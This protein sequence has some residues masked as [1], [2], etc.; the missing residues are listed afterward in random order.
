MLILGC[1][2]LFVVVTCGCMVVETFS[3]RVFASEGLTETVVGSEKECESRY[4]ST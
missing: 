1:W 2:S 3:M 4:N